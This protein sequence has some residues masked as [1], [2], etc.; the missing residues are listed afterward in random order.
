[1]SNVNY[2]NEERPLNEVGDDAKE[3][4]LDNLE[5]WYSEAAGLSK[6]HG[7]SELEE[8]KNYLAK[9]L[10]RVRKTKAEVKLVVEFDG[11]WL[12]AYLVGKT[13]A[14]EYVSW[15]NAMIETDHAA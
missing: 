5:E 14:L 4:T 11:D 15:H 10:K 7:L 12:T 3:V 6:G 9:T 13:K 2:P 8:V 1:M